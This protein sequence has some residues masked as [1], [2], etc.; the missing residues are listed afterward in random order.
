MAEFSVNVVTTAGLALIARAA[1][2][3]QLIYTR[4]LSDADAM[5][6]AAAALATPADFSGPEGT[7]LAASATDVSCR[8]VGRIGNQSTAATVKTFAV[9]A[10]IDGDASDVVV[11]VL[12]D[13]AEIP[14]PDTSS[15][16]T[17]VEIGFLINI[18]SADTVTVQVTGAGSVTFG[19]IARF[20]SCHKAGDPTTGEAQT[21]LGNK[22]F[23]DDVDIAGGLGVTGDAVFAD[24]V[25]INGTL[26]VD[27]A[28][29]EEEVTVGKTLSIVGEGVDNDDTCLIWQKYETVGGDD[30]VQLCVAWPN[31]AAD[32]SRLYFGGGAVFQGAIETPSSLTVG[33]P[34][35]MTST[36]TLSG[37]L[38]VESVSEFKDDVTFSCNIYC[39]GFSVDAD[40]NTEVSSAVCFAAYGTVEI[41][42]LS[43]S[44][45]NN[46]LEVP[47]GGIIGVCPSGVSGWAQDVPA[48]TE[49]TITA[50]LMPAAAWD[51]ANARWD[52][53]PSG[54]TIPKGKYRLVTGWD[55]DSSNTYGLV[56][57]CHVSNS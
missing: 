49:V 51:C 32:Y 56:L 23:S 22:T 28:V 37:A 7:I 9:C 11:A 15:P 33:G 24:D 4:V 19:D 29:T 26:V 42:G 8:V 39:G 53:C 31:I 55:Y 41:P 57:L 17:G 35:T 1:A 10:K 2:A 47:I 34:V 12:S 18:A 21:I 20:V 52:A 43:P 54:R 44:T 40:G 5:T 45:I 48:G 6:A 3:S 16:V 36:V 50:G 14:I 38:T 13:D 30:V 27:G 25:E 46:A